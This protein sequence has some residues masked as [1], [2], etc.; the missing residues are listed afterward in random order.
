MGGQR[1]EM[2]TDPQS[3]L[4]QQEQTNSLHVLGTLLRSF[5]CTPK[6]LTLNSCDFPQRFIE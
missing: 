4:M 2:R 1:I 5:D 3:N 6:L